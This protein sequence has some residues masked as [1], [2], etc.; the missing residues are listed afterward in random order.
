[1]EKRSFNQ[2]DKRHQE[3]IRM[4]AKIYHKAGNQLL[5]LETLNEYYRYT[6]TQKRVKHLAQKI[7]RG[8]WSLPNEND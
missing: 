7:M 2:L 4:L 3:A 6:N 8:N 5:N 1:M